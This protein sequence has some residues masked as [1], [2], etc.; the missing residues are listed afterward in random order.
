MNLSS[1]FNTFEYIPYNNSKSS[2]TDNDFK[3]V[4]LDSLKYNGTDFSDIVTSITD[5]TLRKNVVNN[6]FG[7][8]NFL[9]SDETFSL[10]NQH[11]SKVDKF[12]IIRFKPDNFITNILH[13]YNT[14][15]I[16]QKSTCSGGIIT[17]KNE[18]CE[19]KIDP[20]NIKGNY[21]MVNWPKDFSLTVSKVETGCVNI[22]RKNPGN[23]LARLSGPEKLFTYGVPKMSEL[24]PE[25]KDSHKSEPVL[26]IKP[27]EKMMKLFKEFDNAMMKKIASGSFAGEKYQ[28]TPQNNYLKVKFTDENG[29]FAISTELQENDDD[30]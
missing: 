16:I 15:I 13:N 21:L 5:D 11:I 6:S 22:I 12:Y 7:D 18:C 29:N 23:F 17:F 19:I 24:Y 4:N 30:Y 27:D 1:S 26:N 28:P 14:V 3:M 2:S 9:T 25:P 10:E 8:F 20:N